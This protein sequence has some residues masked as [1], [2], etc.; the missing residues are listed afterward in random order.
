MGTAEV[1]WRCKLREQCQTKKRETYGLDTAEVL[2][3]V[4]KM[5]TAE[6]LNEILV[7]STTEVLDKVNKMNT[8]EV[9]K[10]VF[11]L[12]ATEVL[13]GIKVRSAIEVQVVANTKEV[14]K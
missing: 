8:A 6:V 10:E 12:S 11:V 9:L 5:N 1:Q 3:K 2:D 7:L 13:D 4:S 14:W